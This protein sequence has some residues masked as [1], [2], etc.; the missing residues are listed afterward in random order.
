MQHFNA[1]VDINDEAMSDQQYTVINDR[2][3]RGID[4]L[5]VSY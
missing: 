3:A 2:Q 1:D 4:L 5:H